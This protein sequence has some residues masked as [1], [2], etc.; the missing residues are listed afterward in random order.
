MADVPILVLIHSPL[1]GPMTWRP[2]A[3]RV[4]TLG[5]P[6]MVPSLAGVV[7][8]EG[9]YY[10]KVARRVSDVARQA[11]PEGPVILVGHSGAG[12]LLPVVGE[13]VGNVDAAVFVDAILPH[14][15][16]SWFDTAPRELREQ[17]GALAVGQRLPPWHR[18]F[19]AEA[20]AALLPDENMRARFISE[21]PEVPVAYFEESAPAVDGWPPGAC[22]YVQLSEAYEREAG[23]AERRGW[24]TLREP[25]D[26]LALLTRPDA[27][28]ALLTRLVDALG[29]IPP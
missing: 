16:C 22:G 1:V 3:A 8:D 25:L 18:W 9:P 6:A 23:E 7:D 4:R 14:P 26:H 10:R 11:R 27:V 19:S 13:A 28:A 29:R 2:V 15:G 20:V 12:S 24:L 17:V 21:L 5:Y